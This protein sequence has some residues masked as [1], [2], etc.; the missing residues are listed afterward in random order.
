MGE[1][2]KQPLS[3]T[4]SAELSQGKKWIN[5]IIGIAGFLFLVFL[6]FKMVANK[7]G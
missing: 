2:E 1:A 6:I 7:M 3:N 5:R 4:A